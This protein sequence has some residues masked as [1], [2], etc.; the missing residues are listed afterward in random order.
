MNF[1][2]RSCICIEFLSGVRN[3]LRSAESAPS[4]T[5]IAIFLKKNYCSLAFSICCGRRR[6]ACGRCAGALYGGPAGSAAGAGVPPWPWRLAPLAII[7][8]CDLFCRASRA[9]LSWYRLGRGGRQAPAAA[10]A[11]FRDYESSIFPQAESQHI[12]LGLCVK[13]FRL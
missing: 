2:W 8:F 11:S 1:S 9:P 6:C 5:S 7:A 13:A 4:T 12:P 10:T 3:F